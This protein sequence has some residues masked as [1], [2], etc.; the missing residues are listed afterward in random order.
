[1]TT[2]HALRILAALAVA[3]LL[4]AIGA[5]GASAQG[6]TE[7]E[8]DPSVSNPGLSRA[9]PSDDDDQDDP[10]DDDRDD[11]DRDEDRR[12]KDSIQLRTNKTAAV[13]EGDTVWITVSLRAKVDVDDVRVTATL[14]GEAV[15]YPGNTGDHSGPYNRYDLDRKETDFVAFQIT[16][17]QIDKKKEYVDLELQV[18]WTEDGRARQGTESVKVPVIEFSGEPYELVTDEITL[19]DG[20]NG[21]VQLALAGLTPR[22]DDVRIR[23]AQPTDLDIHYPQETYTSLLRD[24]TLE[25]GETD[26]ANLR[27]GE[28]HWGQTIEVEVRVD[29]VLDAEP[30]TRTHRVTITS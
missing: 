1:M 26:Q 19:T 3:V 5:P 10:E 17:P 16:A 9:E 14:V 11:D 13:V 15:A 18:T 8:T 22:I 30:M 7:S 2:T 21:W 12:L 28:A 29:F 23:L 20:A 24:A 25:D 6:T 27:L 4:T